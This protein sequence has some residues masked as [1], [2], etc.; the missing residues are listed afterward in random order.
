MDKCK[1]V[2]PYNKTELCNKNQPTARR[3][4]MDKPQNHYAEWTKPDNKGGAQPDFI[5]MQL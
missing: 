4:S 5:H 2:H 1:V 3:Q